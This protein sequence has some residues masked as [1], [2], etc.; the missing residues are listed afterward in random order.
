MR[1]TSARARGRTSGFSS[2]P[3]AEGAVAGRQRALH[4][5]ELAQ[6]LARELLRLHG[7]L[8]AADLS[9]Q[10]G[11]ALGQRETVPEPTF[12]EIEARG[13]DEREADGSRGPGEARAS[14]QR[15]EVRDALAAASEHAEERFERL[16]RGDR[17]RVFGPHER[18]HLVVVAGG[19][20]ELASVARG[21]PGLDVEVGRDRGLAAEREVAGDDRRRQPTPERAL[22]EEEAERAMHRRAVTRLARLVGHVA[23]EGVSEVDEV[24]F[25]IAKAARTEADERV[26]AVG[27]GQVHDLIGGERPASDG[28][29]VDDGVLLGGELAQA[30]AEELLER[31]RE[32]PGVGLRAAYECEAWLR[33]LLTLLTDLQRSALEE[34]VDHLE[35]EERVAADLGQ[36]VGAHL[37]NAFADTEPVLHEAHLLFGRE[38]LELD[39]HDAVEDGG[40]AIVGARDEHEEDR[41]GIRRADEL[42]ERVEALSIRPVEPLDDDDE[43]LR[44]RDRGEERPEPG[45]D[46][47]ASIGRVVVVAAAE[48]SVGRELG[49]PRDDRVLRVAL[50]STAARARDQGDDVVE[51]LVAGDADALAYRRS[52]RAVRNLHLHRRGLDADE[53]RVGR[54][55]ARERRHERALSDTHLADDRATRERAHAAHRVV[56]RCVEIVSLDVATDEITLRAGHRRHALVAREAAKERV[57]AHRRRDVLDVGLGRELER[58]RVVPLEL[59]PHQAIHAAGD[60]RFVERRGSHEHVGEVRRWIVESVAEQV[61]LRVAEARRDAAHD[62]ERRAQLGGRIVGEAGDGLVSVEGQPGRIGCGA[63]GVGREPGHGVGLDVARPDPA[64]DAALVSDLFEHVAQAIEHALSAHAVRD[65]GLVDAMKA[66]RDD[67]DVAHLARSSRRRRRLR[68]SVGHLAPRGERSAASTRR[69]RRRVAGFGR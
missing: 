24:A 25:A 8:R 38:A 23:G 10:V 44:E 54:E 49:E 1:S 35:Q 48:G 19:E 9:C 66:Q 6:E 13:A 52:H 31:R 34:R 36:E 42:G 61:A 20:L 18:E 12:V 62:A 33:S 2:V 64:A 67:R 5:P 45:A 21:V 26:F 40:A 51:R 28:E 7:E 47:L 17:A 59:A 53:A 58:R 16:V 37:P 60:P 29:P 11:R 56:I 69:R 46:Q 30:I 65:D 22:P 63:R 4:R 68:R 43:R 15:L 50:R 41:Q 57:D 14:T 3:Q 55:L 32:L 27:V 39:A